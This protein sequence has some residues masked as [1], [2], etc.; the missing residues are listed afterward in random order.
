M[1]NTSFVMSAPALRSQDSCKPLAG[2]A[3]QSTLRRLQDPRDRQMH[4]IVT[5]VAL[6]FDAALTVLVIARVSCTGPPLCDTVVLGAS[7]TAREKEH[8]Y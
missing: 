3:I 7:D 8:N 6:L 5:S 2:S 1:N 4:F